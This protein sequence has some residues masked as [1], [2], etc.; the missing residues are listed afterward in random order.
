MAIERASEFEETP[1]GWAQRWE[2]ELAASKK[3]LKTWQKQSNKVVER[4]LDDREKNSPDDL[5]TKLNLFNANIITLQSMLYGRMPKVEVD[6]RFADQDDDIARVAGQI[7]QRILNTDIESAGEDYAHVLRSALGDRLL[8]GLGTAR[9]KYDFKESKVEVPAQLDPVTGA[10][11][12]PAY[13]DTKVEDEWVDTVY[14]HWKDLLWSPCRTFAEMRWRAYR[15]YLTR[16]ELIARFGEELGKAVPLNSKGP[17]YEKDRDS[18]REKEIWDQ[19]EVWEIW[20]KT[21]KKVFW[22]VEGFDRVLDM[23]E[24]PLG[25]D[26]FF[27]EPPA[28]LANLTTSRYI[29][30]SEYVIAQDLYVQIDILETRITILTA[31]CKAVGVYDKASEEIQRVL[32]EGVENQLIPVDKWAA[33]AEKGGLEGVVDWVP[34]K[35]IAEVITILSDKQDRLI[36]QLYQVTGMADI[37]RGAASQVGVSAT[38][39]AIKAKFASIRVQ[40]LQDEFAR[41][42]SDL[43]RLKAEIIAKHYQPYCIIQQS[44]ISSTPDAMLA[45]PAI[46][47]IKNPNVSRWKIQVKPETLAMVDYA[48]LKQDRVEYINS[49]AVFMQSAAPLLEMEPAAAPFLMQLMKWGLAGFKGSNEIEGV[50]DQAIAAFE[51]S[52]QQGGAQKPD[53]EQIKAQAEIQKAQIGMQKAQMDM[54]RDQ[55]KFQFEMQQMQMEF[56]LKMTEMQEKHRIEMEKLRATVLAERQRQEIQTEANSTEVIVGAAAKKV[57]MESRPKP[58]GGGKSG[59]KSGSKKS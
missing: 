48:Q 46:Q 34:I 44:N 57:E 4:F 3:W 58:A 16:D 59:G 20:D 2:M 52:Q 47:L 35:E 41:F 40:A 9:V 45:E 1:T 49:L 30:K 10:E 33:F 32:M 37:L 5:T 13:T 22:Y 28:M 15:S 19:A 55:Q 54:Q 14:T 6:R 29:P 21:N 43:Q 12:A 27:P 36:N 17:T 26:S 42:A 23:K 53:P 39:Q 11:L 7:L 38:E 56:Q 8:V 18:V 31:A 51:K 25:L 50:V 24:D